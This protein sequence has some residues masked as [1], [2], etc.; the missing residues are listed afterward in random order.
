[1]AYPE[2]AELEIERAALAAGAPLHMR[3]RDW[4]AHVGEAIEYEDRHGRLALPLPALA[5]GHQADN[6]AL[7]T[8]MLRHQDF[9]TVDNLA[10]NE[11]IRAARWPAR[12]QRLS[13]GPLASLV[14]GRE[15][16]LDGGHN[17]DAGAAIA[18]HF[19]GPVHIVIGMLAN[20]NPLAIIEPLGE[21]IASLSVVPI[22]GSE[23]HPASA[24]GPRA[25]AY[26]SVEE[27]LRTI[28]AEGPILIAGSLYLA[29]EVLRAN[30]EI[31]D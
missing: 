5:G 22:T 31:P 6:A 9:V 4:T 11:G 21:R 8:A 23:C 13:D 26:G 25:R 19:T 10:I 3:G 29:G 12:L 30:G 17:P 28:G 16:W 24:F 2:A 27:A 15:L 7:A 20:K 18:R 1:M 14:P